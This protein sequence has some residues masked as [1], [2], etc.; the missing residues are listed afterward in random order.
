MSMGDY[1]SNQY[2]TEKKDNGWWYRCKQCGSEAGGYDTEEICRIM[3][4][5]HVMLPHPKG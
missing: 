2:A 1:L 3:A 4:D 5:R